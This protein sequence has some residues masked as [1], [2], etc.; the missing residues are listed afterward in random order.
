MTRFLLKW[1]IGRLFLR[2]IKKDIEDGKTPGTPA[3]SELLQTI[4]EQIQVARHEQKSISA[5]DIIA[6]MMSMVEQTV[7][8]DE[9]STELFGQLAIQLFTNPKK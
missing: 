8:L 3:T 1:F 2:D 7:Q 5:E 9:K 4:Q 6:A